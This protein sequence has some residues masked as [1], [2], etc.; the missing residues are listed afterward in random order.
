MKTRTAHS[1]ERRLTVRLSALS[2]AVF[3]IAAAGYL[4]SA[5]N[6]REIEASSALFDLAAELGAR[7][8][9]GDGGVPVLAAD[10]ALR[11]RM[12]AIPDFQAVIIDP[13][14]GRL[15]AGSSLWLAEHLP[16]QM[17]AWTKA[18]FALHGDAGRL[19]GVIETVAGP[20][21]PLL[22]ALVR[23]RPSG[24]EVLDWAVTEVLE[25]IVP[26][27]LP[28]MVLTMVVGAA[29]VRS[30]LRPLRR[31][32]AEAGAIEP[33]A[34]DVRLAET[35]VPAEILPLVRAVNRAFDRI[36][37]GLNRQR[38]MTANAA[39]EL[40]TPLAVLRAR[41][42][43]AAGV[44]ATAALV[45]PLARDV[46]RMARIVD[47]LMSVAR[48]EAD[49]VEV[50]ERVDLVRTVRETLADFAPLVLASG[51]Q[52]EL[53]APERPVPIR[54]N[55]LALDEAL[56]NLMENALRYTP[57]GGSIEVVVA[58]G[59][60]HGGPVALEVRDRGPGIAE[61]DRPRVFEPFWRGADRRNTGS[62][63]GLAIVRETVLRHGGSVAALARDGGGAVI[64]IEFPAWA[65]S[66]TIR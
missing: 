6:G 66:L 4:A 31:L 34:A 18:E 48:L 47:Q 30:T 29:T 39:H 16:P 37:E 27:L 22:A 7:V 15:I 14:D 52:L 60:P 13:A 1:L 23:G 38:R 45:G 25:E 44:A 35:D 20:G 21:G 17:H 42:D 2:L 28:M 19:H 50:E 59:L 43:G 57:P 64:R 61:A 11:R 63:L 62:G 9:R 10:A 41:L 51:R 33:H 32:S 56:R 46:A 58:D 26:I 8:E 3:V 5:W 53:A 65:D 54:G 24:A 49:Q 12:A 36:E 55:A 40:R